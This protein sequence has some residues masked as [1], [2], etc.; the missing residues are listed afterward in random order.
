MDKN[1]YNSVVRIRSMSTS[2]NW[3]FPYKNDDQPS[4]GTGFFINDEGFI[5]TCS[6][7]TENSIKI[8][9]TVPETGNKEYECKLISVFPELDISI[10][11]ADFKNKGFLQLGD[12]DHLITGQEV[13]AIGYPLGQ[14]K[15]KI[16]KG[17]ISGRDD[18]FIQTDTAL[19]PGNSGG[20]LVDK[21][22]K[23]I[24]I[25]RAII[26]NAENIGFATPIFFF[27]KFKDQ[28]FKEKIIYNC[29]LGLLLEETG[30]F[31]LEY[32]G[33]KDICHQ[34][35]YVKD[36]ISRKSLSKSKIEKGDVLCKLNNY[37][38]DFKGE[39]KVSWYDERMPIKTIINRF[40]KNEKVKITFW[41]NQ[42][43][44]L[45]EEDHILLTTNEL[46]PIRKMFPIIEPI[47]YE[48]FAGCIFM[49][50]CVNHYAVLENLSMLE[51]S[52]KLGH[53]YVIITHI[54]ASSYSGKLK[55]LKSGDLIDKINDIKVNN[56]HQLRNALKTPIKNN[57]K[58]FI[59]IK[60]KNNNMIIYNLNNII[61]E[62][63]FLSNPSAYNYQLTQVSKYYIE[64]MK[65]N[66]QIE[67]IDDNH[68]S[69]DIDNSDKGIQESL[70]NNKK[71][72]S[73][74]KKQNNKKSIKIINKID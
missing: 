15:L 35:V 1:I 21:N 10:I 73:K 74:T 8:W 61:L 40:Q 46:Y 54:F 4:V 11:K 5:L 26:V 20:P 56:L 71:S 33:C 23:V 34:G 9:I 41:S 39:C 51:V 27:H 42:K 47:D 50:L 12:S 60:T 72:S 57:K 64:K 63:L 58:E 53:E 66:K 17:I 7:V 49:N 2:L 25:N 68:S 44:K 38:I 59:E 28:L 69:K 36:I 22:H 48:I 3:V 65:K 70:N 6:H 52:D 14:D 31:L 24:G 37:N 32:Y 19:N 55:V 45:I 43:K 30:E 13:L 16:T 18:D 67:F 29:S 62:Q